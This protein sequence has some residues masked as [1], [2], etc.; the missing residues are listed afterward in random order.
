MKK[1]GLDTYFSLSDVDKPEF[2]RL[3]K[4]INGPVYLDSCSTGAPQSDGECVAQAISR[5]WNTEVHAPIIPL[6]T[7]YT[8]NLRIYGCKCRDTFI[9]DAVYFEDFIFLDGVYDVE[10]TPDKSNS[11]RFKVRLNPQGKVDSIDNSD[12]T[13]MTPK[14]KESAAYVRESIDNCDE[15]FYKEMIKAKKGTFILSPNLI[16]VYKNG[17]RIK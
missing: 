9:K 13:D 16:A 2:V 14:Q 12:F 4:Y 3:K 1:L 15:P 11:F 17:K 8:P 7:G 10:H 5:V 6:A